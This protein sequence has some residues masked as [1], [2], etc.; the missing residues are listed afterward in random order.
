MAHMIAANA[1]GLAPGPE[2]SYEFRTAGKRHKF[3]NM[4][5]SRR[6]LVPSRLLPAAHFIENIFVF[7]QLLSRTLD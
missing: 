3:Q 2:L 7:P 4:P 1:H 5:R 6:A